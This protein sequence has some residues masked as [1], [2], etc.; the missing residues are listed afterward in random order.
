MVWHGIGHGMVWLDPIAGVAWSNT[1][2][3]QG[4]ENWHDG[5]AW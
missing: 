2:H 3:W 1:D 4:S 5:M